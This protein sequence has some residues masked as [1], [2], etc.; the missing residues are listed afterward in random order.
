MPTIHLD[1]LTNIVLEVAEVLPETRYLL[2]VDDSKLTLY[3]ILKVSL[4]LINDIS[5]NLLME[6]YY[7]RPLVRQWE[8]VWFEKHQKMLPFW[9]PSLISQ[10]LICSK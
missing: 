2:A 7:Q 5:I 9:I 8:P 10:I 6:K 4:S 3:D 1:D